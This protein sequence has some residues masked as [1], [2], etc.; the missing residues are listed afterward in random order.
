MDKLF[1]N[2]DTIEEHQKIRKKY[3]ILRVLQENIYEDPQK[4]KTLCSI[5]KKMKWNECLQ[6]L[7]KGIAI[8]ADCAISLKITLADEKERHKVSESEVIWKFRKGP[9]KWG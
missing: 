9:K 6:K 4:F 7:A 3:N 2:E 5:F 1:P 8:D